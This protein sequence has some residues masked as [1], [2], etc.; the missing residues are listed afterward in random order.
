ML[1]WD[2]NLEEKTMT[3]GQKISALVGVAVLAIIGLVV[4]MLGG[5]SSA[6]AA[7]AA[8]KK[9]PAQPSVEKNK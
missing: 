3:K 1:Y 4:K 7:P 2:G 8:D 6:P 9:M 5:E